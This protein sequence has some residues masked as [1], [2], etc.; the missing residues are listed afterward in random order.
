M[1]IVN[2]GR[3]LIYALAWTVAGVFISFLV[4]WYFVD[5][6]MVFLYFILGAILGA[7]VGTVFALLTTGAEMPKRRQ[8]MKLLRRAAVA[9]I[10]G[11]AVIASI[12]L[13]WADV[14]IYTPFRDVLAVSVLTVSCAILLAGLSSFIDP[15]L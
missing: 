14:R 11:V 1:T 8:W 15:R 10:G 12:W 7:V 3:V 2:I 9:G 5:A 6:D 13:A 4:V